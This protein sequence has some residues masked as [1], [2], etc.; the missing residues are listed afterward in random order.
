MATSWKR[1]SLSVCIYTHKGMPRVPSIWKKIKGA[2]T[3]LNTLSQYTNY[4]AW[5]RQ[6]YKCETLAQLAIVH[7]LFYLVGKEGGLGWWWRRSDNS[8]SVVKSLK[9]P[10]CLV[11]SLRV[12]LYNWSMDMCMPLASMD[13][14]QICPIGWERRWQYLESPQLVPLNSTVDQPNL[15]ADQRVNH[16]RI[17]SKQVQIWDS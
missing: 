9:H 14:P 10:K 16:S 3:A 7:G 8:Y 6:R 1:T 13:R 11:P 2:P 15:T 17:L 5:S 12:A 4:H